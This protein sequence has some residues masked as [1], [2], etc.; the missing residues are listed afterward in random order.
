M[1]RGGAPSWRQ[2]SRCG[3]EGVELCAVSKRLGMICRQVPE[4]MPQDEHEREAPRTGARHRHIR[5]CR[6]CNTLYVS[7]P[8]PA[9][10]GEPGVGG[11]CSDAAP[12]TSNT[13]MTLAQ[14]CRLTTVA[15]CPQL[16]ARRAEV[17]DAVVPDMLRTKNLQLGLVMDQLVAQQRSKCA[18]FALFSCRFQSGSS[19]C[20]VPNV[21]AQSPRHGPARRAAALQAAG[22]A[23]VA[24]FAKLFHCHV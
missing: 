21:H 6:C 23:A 24:A 11:G 9:A 22:A 4:T 17:L 7:A 1:R 10:G 18:P 2:T 12:A 19:N 8:L 13:S 15:S 14:H 3:H 20:C 16:A 5:E